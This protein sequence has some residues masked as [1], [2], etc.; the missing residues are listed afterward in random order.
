MKNLLVALFAL[1]A[2]SASAFADATVVMDNSETVKTGTG[3]FTCN[4]IT[5][6]VVT[7]TAPNRLN[8]RICNFNNC[9]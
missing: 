9:I 6:L 5:P 7:T 4:V 3:T 8:G 1:V 2:I